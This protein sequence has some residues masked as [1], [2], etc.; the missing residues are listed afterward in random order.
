MMS[1]KVSSKLMMLSDLLGDIATVSTVT[2]CEIKGL[3]IND[4]GVRP[5]Y[6][7]FALA[8]AG[9]HGLEY[10]ANALERGA[11]AVVWDAG[12]GNKANK[13]E[14][15]LF[16]QHQRYKDKVPVIPVVGLKHKLGF[17]A[18]KYYGEPSKQLHVIGITGTNGK[19][20]CAHFLAQALHQDAPAAV[21]GTLGNGLVNHLSD[22]THT[23]PDAVTVHQL[24]RRY[25]DDGAKNVIMEV[26]SHGLVQGRVV[27]INFEI[28]I[29]TNLSRDH[30]DYHGDM[31]SYA[32]AK[33][34]LFQMPRL[35][36]AVINSDDVYG[37]NIMA[38][39]R[40]D[41][42]AATPRVISYGMKHNH[43][44]DSV[45]ALDVQ[46]SASGL[47]FKVQS[48][49]GAGV[50]QSPLLG[51]FN[52]SNL[53]AVLS[54]LLIKG[55]SFD[56]ALARVS[57]LKTIAGRMERISETEDSALFVVDYAHTPDALQKAL[58]SLRTHMNTSMSGKLWCLFGCG[59]DRDRGKRCEMGAIAQQFA[60]QIVI[61]DDNP[62]TEISKEIIADIVTGLEAPERA[63]L[64]PDRV[65]AI[66]FVVDAAGDNDVVLVAGKG[67]EEYQIIGTK[68][69]AYA[70]DKAVLRNL[71]QR[72]RS[73]EKLR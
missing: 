70:G 27:G 34:S 39:L 26:S 47:R 23:T 48:P 37:R 46:Y 71:L 18:E 33:N 35:K 2:D 1:A 3:A 45:R 72:K 53:L 22:A 52:V 25:L 42:H 61:A 32:A 30:L 17:M 44:K 58:Q 21:V 11:C 19:T 43:H 56:E 51:Q 36:A 59:G 20:S 62:R 69:Q 10:A 49:W 65:A 55:V 57:Y 41:S 14:L 28:A 12:D 60:D 8:G 5:G 7:F 67:H 64:I 9:Q 40:N 13:S 66:Q 54:T 29:F 73:G 38:S 50:V 63:V 6:V 16:R 31:Q 24:I 68:K 4:A 15:L